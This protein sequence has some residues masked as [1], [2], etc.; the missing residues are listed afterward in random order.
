MRLSFRRRAAGFSLIELLVALVISATLLAIV[1]PQYQSYVLRSRT[2]EAFTALAGVQLVAEQYWS[3]NRSYAG[4][5][6]LPTATENFTYALTTGTASA[7]KVTATGIGKMDGFSYTI[8]QTGTRA[9]PGAPSGWTTSTSC[10]VDR[11]DG[12]CTQ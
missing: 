8:D 6:P 4:L 9:T 10:W 1:L 12:S 7:Y 5:T 2:T 11:K 3:N